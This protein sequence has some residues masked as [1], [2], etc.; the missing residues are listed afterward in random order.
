MLITL[1]NLLQASE[2]YFVKSETQA[3]TLGLFCCK[4]GVSAPS[5]ARYWNY[6]SLPGCELLGSVKMDPGLKIRHKEG[7][8]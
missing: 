8:L 2:A 1:V 5:A 3:S 7:Q 4:H 6:N